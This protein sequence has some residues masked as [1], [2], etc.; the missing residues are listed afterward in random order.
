[1][2][3]ITIKICFTYLTHFYRWSQ[4]IRD[5][6]VF[7]PV[8]KDIRKAKQLNVK[9]DP[10]HLKV[11]ILQE[12]GNCVLVDQ[13]FSHQVKPDECLWSLVGEHVQVAFILFI[14]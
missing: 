6:D 12:S 7:I 11:E 9:I 5:I 3:E 14:K 8:T 2:S 10:L 13:T 4:T 1:M